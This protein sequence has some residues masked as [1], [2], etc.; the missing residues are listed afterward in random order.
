MSL[1]PSSTRPK[2]LMEVLL[3][4]KIEAASA[5]GGPCGPGGSKLFRT[6]SLDSVSS[7]GSCG[8]MGTMMGEDVCRCDDC[9]LG[10][11]D[12]WIAGPAE[13]ALAL[14][15]VYNP[16]ETYSLQPAVPYKS[17]EL[18]VFGAYTAL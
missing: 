10:I 14:K 7:V 4:K 15:K 13:K 12:L 6:D 17:P 1:Y 2:T 9:L 5:G 16:N 18:M 11:V 3:A 8:S